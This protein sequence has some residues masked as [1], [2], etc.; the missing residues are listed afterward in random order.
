MARSIADREGDRE[1]G[2]VE[3]DGGFGKA[4]PVEA[5]ADAVRQRIALD[6]PAEKIGVEPAVTVLVVIA[7]ERMKPGLQPAENNRHGP[8][9]FPPPDV[10]SGIVPIRDLPP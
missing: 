2:P 1:V 9:A 10:R 8:G 3:P 7:A 5:Q 6:R 4:R